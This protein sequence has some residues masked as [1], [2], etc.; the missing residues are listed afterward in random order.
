[1][2]IYA[3]KDCPMK[4]LLEPI[5]FE[6]NWRV[7]KIPEW[8]AF[9][10]LSIPQYFQGIVNMNQTNNTIVAC[11]HDYTYSRI[12]NHPITRKESDRKL[13]KDIAWFSRHFIYIWIRVWWYFSWKKDTNYHKYKKQIDDTLVYLKLEK[14]WL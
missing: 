7:Y 13:K 14:Q 1:M 8:Y 11:F 4:I 6:I 12:H 2:Y 9:D 10:W 5:Y 3:I